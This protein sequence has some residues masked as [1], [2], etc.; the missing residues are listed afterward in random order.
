MLGETQC[1]Y[2]NQGRKLTKKQRQKAKSDAPL[3]Q[4][5]VHGDKTSFESLLRRKLI[6]V[7]ARDCESGTTALMETIISNQPKM[8]SVLIARNANVNLS[9]HSGFTALM[10]AAGY[11]RIEVVKELLAAGADVNARIKSNGWTALSMASRYS[12]STE[13]QS[14]VKILKDNGAIE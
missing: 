13:H 9:N 3:I 7:N 4:A 5:I 14:V 2:D 6:D 8:M 10:Y 11:G 12:S 1:V